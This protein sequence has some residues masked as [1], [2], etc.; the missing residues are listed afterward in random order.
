MLQFLWKGEEFD[1]HNES[2]YLSGML[3]L[4]SGN[5]FTCILSFSDKKH[6][7]GKKKKKRLTM[8]FK[9]LSKQIFKLCKTKKGC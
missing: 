1:D 3:P 6:N 4:N 5:S 8:S 7:F 9:E 2:F